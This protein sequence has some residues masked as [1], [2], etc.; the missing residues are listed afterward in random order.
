MNVKTFEIP[1]FNRKKIF[2][3]LK[4]KHKETKKRKINGFDNLTM[5]IWK[6]WMLQDFSPL[7]H[8]PH[9]VARNTNV[10]I[11]L[12]NVWTIL[13]PLTTNF[14]C[15]FRRHAYLE[16][17]IYFKKHC[18]DFIIHSL[19]RENKLNWMKS[20]KKA[21]FCM[22]INNWNESSQ[23]DWFLIVKKMLHFRALL[24]V[25]KLQIKFGFYIY[26]N[27]SMAYCLK[28]G[29]EQHFVVVLHSEL[30][31]GLQY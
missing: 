30:K 16:I 6:V 20:P 22:Y 24:S 21:R 29:I 15:F 31:H 2:T 14:C 18:K 26:V 10:N 3:G 1:Y 5:K 9:A 7:D 4:E 8:P 25:I 12:K 17:N 28:L 27:L 19:F 13:F 11:F 23:N